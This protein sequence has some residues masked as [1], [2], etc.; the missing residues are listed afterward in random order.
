ML[1]GL[2]DKHEWR[3]LTVGDRPLT[4]APREVRVAALEAFPQVVEELKQAAADAIAR[5]EKAKKFVK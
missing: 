3:R 1:H 4:E 5:I 2:D